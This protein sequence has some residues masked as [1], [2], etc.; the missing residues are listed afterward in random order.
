MDVWWEKKEMG[1]RLKL[2][3]QKQDPRSP[4]PRI[5]RFATSRL[6]GTN[7]RSHLGADVR[8][9]CAV[10]EVSLGFPRMFHCEEKKGLVSR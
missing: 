7:F 2:A 9:C 1:E 5:P 3:G 6:P 8:S 4:N 10:S